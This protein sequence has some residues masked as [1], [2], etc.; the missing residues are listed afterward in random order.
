VLGELRSPAPTTTP[1]TYRRVLTANAFLKKAL[2]KGITLCL[3]KSNQKAAFLAPQDPIL[4]HDFNKLTV[5]VG[6]PVNP[7]QK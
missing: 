5:V 7:R 3:H 1:T 4:A 2:Q 6:C